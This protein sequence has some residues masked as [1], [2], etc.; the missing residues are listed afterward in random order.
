MTMSGSET[1]IKT[2]TTTIR[3]TPE[4]RAD[5]AAAAEAQ[6]VG[7]SSF[8]RLATLR[9]IGRRPAHA[10]KRRDPHAIERARILGEL[11][12][13]GNN[14]NQLAR[15]AHRGGLV[16]PDELQALRAAVERLTQ[17]VMQ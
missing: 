1:R 15:H 11:G 2:S 10:L 14:V 8:A 17:A 4:E 3:L 5:L 12:R 7:P 16:D 6:G 9:A 13:I